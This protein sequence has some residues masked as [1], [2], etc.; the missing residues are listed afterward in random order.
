MFSILEP[1]LLGDA[2]SLLPP[3]LST[4]PPSALPVRELPKLGEE[5]PRLGIVARHGDGEPAVHVGAIAGPGGPELADPTP[6]QPLAPRQTS[7]Y[8]ERMFGYREA[9]RCLGSRRLGGPVLLKDL[10]PALLAELHAGD[11][12]RRATPPLDA[13]LAVPGSPA[14]ETA[15]TSFSRAA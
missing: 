10:L 13:V 14:E 8:T 9:S 2:P 7:P 3:F 1:C 12:A 15:P 5:R 6:S 11:V 4:R